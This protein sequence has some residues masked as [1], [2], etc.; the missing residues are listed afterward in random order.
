[1]ALFGLFE[2]SETLYF[3]GCFSSAFARSKIE[4]Y[5]RI[6]KKLR[7]DFDLARE[8][9]I[10]CCGGF[11]DEA[12]YEKNLRK[13]SRDNLEVLRKK[14][15][16]KIITNCPLCLNTL[17][18]YREM[19]PDWDIEVEFILQAI[20]SKLKE[21]PRASKSYFSEPIAYYDSCY[22]ARYSQITEQPRELLMMLGYKLIEL[23]KNRE[24]TLCCGS[25]GNLPATN[26][27][28]ANKIA[29]DFIKMLKRNGIKKVATPD[30]RAYHHLKE[31]LKSAGI[32]EEEIRVLEISDLICG[33]LN[34]NIS[35]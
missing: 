24:E 15:I 27:E 32:Q 2:D 22:L 16:K 5:R 1:M 20:L 28:L 19:L 26:P 17:K 10:I 18:S 34:I 12:G 25:C 35:L 33:S 11:L 21:N 8:K 3:P 30:I 4:N 7:V 9:D 23:P 14:G 13:S 29:A 6:L 31:F